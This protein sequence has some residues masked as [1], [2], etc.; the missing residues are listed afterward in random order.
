MA[1]SKRMPKEQRRRQLLDTAYEMVR[2]EGTDALTLARLAERAGVTK[3]IAY[4]HFGSRPGLLAALYRHYEERQTAAMQAA[5]A[6]DGRTLEDVAQI[7]AGAYV[8]CVLTAGPECDEIASALSAFEETKDFLQASRDYYVEEFRRAFASLASLP[9]EA[10]RAVY[11]GLLG[12]A[13]TLSYAAAS[14][15]LSRDEAVDALVRIMVGTLA[16]AL[17]RPG[18][19]QPMP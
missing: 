13:E 4:A 9:D 3:P 18:A 6:A 11:A 12:A 7:V 8:D 1:A 16:P 2:A 19:P 15:R 10:G 14:G 5:V 17:S